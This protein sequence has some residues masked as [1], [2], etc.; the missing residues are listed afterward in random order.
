MKE[1]LY[2]EY[3][4]ARAQQS[5]YATICNNNF[6][7]HKKDEADYAFW[8]KKSEILLDLLENQ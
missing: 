8:K 7:T 4:E 5:Y 6:F 2:R 1:E 3:A